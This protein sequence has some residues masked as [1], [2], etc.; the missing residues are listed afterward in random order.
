ML[1]SGNN[2][3]DTCSTKRVSYILAT[4]NRAEFL[5]KSLEAQ[6]TLFSPEDELIIVDGHSSDHTAEIARQ[7]SNLVDIFISEPDW[8][9]ADAWNKGILLARGKY[10]KLLTDDDTIHTEGMAQAIAAMEK[11]PEVDLLLCGG[12]KQ[13]KNKI[14]TIWI[15]PG[16]NYG[17]SVKDVFKHG[18]PGIGHVIRRQAFARIGLFDVVNL[19]TDQEFAVRA[20]SLGANIKFCRINLYHHPIL[21]HSVTV[22]QAKNHEKHSDALLKEYTSRG[23]YFWF[24]LNRFLRRRPLLYR[25]LATPPYVAILLKEKGL[26]VTA[27]RIAR[28]LFKKKPATTP[29]PEDYAWDGGFS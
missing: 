7:F 26:R 24:R 5:R 12:T 29:R 28:F 20:I 11:H 4:R 2:T 8:G 17:S 23:Y 16:T 14:S 13:R 27:G 6:R 9:P 21:D 15:S 1:S 3:F 19:A 18:S 22:A 10:V 25:W